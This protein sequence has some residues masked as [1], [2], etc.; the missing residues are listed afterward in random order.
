MVL[1]DVAHFMFR[2]VGIHFLEITQKRRLT[3]TPNLLETKIKEVKNDFEIT[4]ILKAHLNQQSR[5]NDI[6]TT[7]P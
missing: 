4:S 6:H 7:I 1:M 3:I 2:V 5:W